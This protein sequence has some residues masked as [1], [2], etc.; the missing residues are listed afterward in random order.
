MYVL[1]KQA[2]VLC[3]TKDTVTV[4]NLEC[5]CH[6]VKI[7]FSSENFKVHDVLFR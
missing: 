6:V 5:P 1:C 3:E 4:E 2:Y 7:L